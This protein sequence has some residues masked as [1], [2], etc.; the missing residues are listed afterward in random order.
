MKWL[1]PLVFLLAISGAFAS[2]PAESRGPIAAATCEQGPVVKFT[3]PESMGCEPAAQQM[4]AAYTARNWMRK[5]FWVRI[6]VINGLRIPD[7]MLTQA[8]KLNK[9]LNLTN[10]QFRAVLQAVIPALQADPK[11]T[12]LLMRCQT[13]L[14][15]PKR[16][17]PNLIDSLTCHAVCAVE[18]PDTKSRL[19]IWIYDSYFG[20][21]WVSPPGKERTERLKKNPAEIVA[22]VYGRG[23][24]QEATYQP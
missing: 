9:E 13:V 23:T 5:Y 17:E 19:T 18:W 20:S 24:F 1:I 14:A 16:T 7:A 12:A 4:A 8:E 15:I 10:E 3:A 11:N 2:G 22:L 21:Y 6:I